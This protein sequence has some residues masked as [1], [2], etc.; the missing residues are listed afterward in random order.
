MVPEEMFSLL[1]EAGR[2]T[3]SSTGMQASSIIRVTDK[4]LRREIAQ[5]SNQEYVARAQSL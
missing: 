1:M 2:R 5:V 4:E 3:A